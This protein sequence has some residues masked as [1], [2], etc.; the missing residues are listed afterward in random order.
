MPPRMQP[1]AIAPL[2]PLAPLVPMNTNL[3][4]AIAAGNLEEVKIQF[5]LNPFTGPYSP[6]CHACKN[7]NLELVKFFVENQ[8]NHQGNH[9][10]NHHDNHQ[11]NHHGEQASPLIVACFGRN[12]EII[13]FLIKNWVKAPLKQDDIRVIAFCTPEVVECL[14]ENIPDF[15]IQELVDS[16]CRIDVFKYLV[17]KVGAVPDSKTFV[18]AQNLEKVKVLLEKGVLGP[19]DLDKTGCSPLLAAIRQE[20]L[21]YVNSFLFLGAVPEIEELAATCYNRL[22]M[23]VFLVDYLGEKAIDVINKVSKNGLPLVDIVIEIPIL[24]FLILKGLDINTRDI[25]GNTPLH[26]IQ[27][28]KKKMFLLEQGLEV[29]ARN[30][31]GETP[32]H[33]GICSGNLEA[34]KFFLDNGADVTAVDNDAFT[35]FHYI[36]TIINEKEMLEILAVVNSAVLKCIKFNTKH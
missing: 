31:R 35:V 13:K 19:N 16:A 23:L 22:D 14:V 15:N 18:Y 12:L 1:E 26:H 29:D 24:K 21:G 8:G 6:L 11:G 30:A 4:N 36:S 2:V 9:H 7:E 32:L 17:D 5:K 25:K 20:D 10:G 3:V 27:P 33:L 34:V 28:L